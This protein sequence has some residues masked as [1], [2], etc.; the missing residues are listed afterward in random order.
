MKTLTILIPVYNEERTVLQLVRQLSELPSGT[1]NQCIFVDDGS[2]DSS[3][4]LLNQALLKV[5]FPHLL[6]KKEH[7]GKAS[8]IKEGAKQILSLDTEG[9]LL[10]HHSL[11]D[12]VVET[13]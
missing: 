10:N 2:T 6:L 5:N 8:A 13:K 11:G 1:V 4:E 12:T 3:V 9:F 7:G